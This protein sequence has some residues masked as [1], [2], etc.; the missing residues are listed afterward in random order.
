MI[1]L[2]IKKAY[3]CLLKS[4]HL[5]DLLNLPNS[6]VLIV[7]KMELFTVI[8]WSTDLSYILP[9]QCLC[10]RQEETFS[11]RCLCFLCALQL[12]SFYNMRH[13][14]WKLCYVCFFSIL[15]CVPLC[16]EAHQ[17]PMQLSCFC[18][19]PSENLNNKLRNIAAVQVQHWQQSLMTCHCHVICW[20]IYG[21]TPT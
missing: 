3:Y 7:T 11:T 9:G 21:C 1:I 14:T 13:I 2:F 12:G 8:T 18:F 20:H 19:C 15:K 6:S 17:W 5:T 4:A 16:T 10:Q